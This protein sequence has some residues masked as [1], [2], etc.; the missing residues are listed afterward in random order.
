MLMSFL[1]TKLRDEYES[2]ESLCGDLEI[3]VEEIEQTLKEAGFT[4]DKERNQVR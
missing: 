3:S 1:N 2:L 4:Y